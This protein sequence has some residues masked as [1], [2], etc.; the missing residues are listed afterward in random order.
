MQSLKQLHLSQAASL[1][2][3]TLVHYR[4]LSPELP[5]RTH[6]ERSGCVC[7]RLVGWRGR[8]PRRVLTLDLHQALEGVFTMERLP[9]VFGMHNLQT[10]LPH[11]HAKPSFSVRAHRRRGGWKWRQRGRAELLGRL[12]PLEERRTGRFCALG[13]GA[14]DW[15]R[16]VKLGGEGLGGVGAADSVY[17]DGWWGRRSRDGVWASGDR[18][19]FPADLQR[20][21]RYCRWS[22]GERP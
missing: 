19:M 17:S 21:E 12:H 2:P 9:A 16:G 8:S 6:C 13:P 14:C 10:M 20:A 1:S 5:H 3:Q 15:R 22:L 7:W 4:V 11:G 18:G